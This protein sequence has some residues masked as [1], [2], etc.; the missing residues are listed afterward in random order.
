MQFYKTDAKAVACY[1][2]DTK[3]L[4]S[5]RIYNIDQIISF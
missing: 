4:P 5:Y 2:F 3:I 1:P